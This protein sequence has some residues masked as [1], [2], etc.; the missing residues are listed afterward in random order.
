MK[1]GK[2]TSVTYTVCEDKDGIMTITKTTTHTE[3]RNGKPGM[4]IMETEHVYKR[5]GQ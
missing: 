4:S 3:Y 1:N 2:E 5:R